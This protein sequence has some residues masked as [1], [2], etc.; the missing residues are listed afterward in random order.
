MGAVVVEHLDRLKRVLVQVLTYNFEFTEHAIRRRNEVAADIVCLKNIEEF[1][2]TG[3]QQLNSLLQR[4]DLHCLC[5]DRNR[6]QPNIGNPSRKKTDTTEGAPP[7]ACRICA[8]SAPSANSLIFS[9]KILL[10]HTPSLISR[11]SRPP[12]IANPRE[13]RARTPALVPRIRGRSRW[14][15]I[16]HSHQHRCRATD[17]RSNNCDPGR[18]HAVAR[19][20]L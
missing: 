1:T 12:V 11:S 14:S 17:C 3:P 9:S 8:L 10:T 13:R 16:R 20:A 19:H 15:C 5:R 18:F 4:D 6:I 2:R 7:S